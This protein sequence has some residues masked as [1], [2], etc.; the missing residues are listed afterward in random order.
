MIDEGLLQDVAQM[1]LDVFAV[2]LI[3]EARRLITITTIKN[4]F[5][6]CGFSID[7]VN[8]NDDSL[9]HGAE[10]FLKSCQ[11]RSH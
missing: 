1:K 9:T 3:A 5:V 4:C 8:S 10:P 7:H 2:H 11:L 6:K